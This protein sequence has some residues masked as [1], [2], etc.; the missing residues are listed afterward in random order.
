[1]PWCPKCKNEYRE[2]IKTCADCGTELVDKLDKEDASEYT[3]LTYI[4]EEELAKKFVAYMEYSKMPAKYEYSEEINEY[5]IL[6]RKKDKKKAIVEFQAFSKVE[7]ERVLAQVQN[8]ANAK[9]E[10]C[11]E[12]T[13]SDDDEEK[14]IFDTGEDLFEDVYPDSGSKKASDAGEMPDGDDMVSDFEDISEEEY[15]DLTADEGDEESDSASDKKAGLTIEVK[16]RKSAGVY[17]KKADTAKDMTSTAVTFFAFAVLLLAFSALNMFNVISY[18]YNNITGLILLFAMS[19]C[20]C[21]VGF[22][23]LKRAK[24]A[25]EESVEEEAFTATLNDWMEKNISVMTDI[26]APEAASEKKDDA[27]DAGEESKSDNDDEADASDDNK[28]SSD[29]SIELLYLNRTTAMKE[30]ITKAFGELDE[31]YLDSLIDEFYDRHF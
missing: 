12:L 25:S 28:E 6:V 7:A 17:V 2:G 21:L 29:A 19:I 30:A 18:F 26:S 8:A 23:A 27:G 16:E 9:E 5:C 4:K 31:S 20:C 14:S 3:R 10:G 15:M 1:M 22:N 24:K 13:S 11:I